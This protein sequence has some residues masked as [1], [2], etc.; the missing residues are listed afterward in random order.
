MQD[1]HVAAGE[2]T[3]SIDS[4]GQAG[5]LSIRGES[6]PENAFELYR[7]VI[8]WIDD[9]LS[10]APGAFRL[11]LDLL[12]LNTS[13]VRAMMDI[14]DL[15]ERAHLGGRDVAVEWRYEPENEQVVEL[16][17]EFREDYTMRFAIVPAD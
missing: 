14:L 12:Y 15:L 17:E 5:W 10:S 8:R 2:S 1:L 4:D 9:W 7:P 3:P 11:R 6:Y 16:A 13:S